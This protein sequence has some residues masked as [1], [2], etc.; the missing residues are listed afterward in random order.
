MKDD[1]P[2]FILRLEMSWCP[3]LCRW[4]K[5]ASRQTVRGLGFF[6][7][8]AGDKEGCCQ[9]ESRENNHPAN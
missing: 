5:L 3:F 1:L 8:K 7:G 2:V 4:F 9:A 6:D